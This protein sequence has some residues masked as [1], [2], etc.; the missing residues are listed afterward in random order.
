MAKKTV[1]PFAF[2][3]TLSILLSAQPL[4]AQR[5]KKQ[6]KCTLCGHD[7]ELLERNG[8]SHGPFPFA[9][10]T[11]ED[12]QIDMFWDAV[13]IET[14]HFRIAA[15]L[16]PWKVPESERKAYRA[17][18]TELQKKW[19]AI[20]PKKATL[21]PWLRA[22]LLADRCERAYA[23]FEELMGITPE[24]FADVEGLRARKMGPYLGM[25]DKFE[26][27]IF[28]DRAPFREFMEKTW[29]LTY[30][31]PQRWNNVDRGCLWFG[32]N[33]EEEDVR[34]DQHL[35]NMIR[36]NIAHNMLDGYMFYSYDLPVWISEGFAHWFERDNDPRFNMF[37]TV[38][39]SFHA[40][41]SLEKWA[42]EV[43]KLV[44]KGDAATYSSL[45]RRASFAEIDFN[46]HLVTWSK[47]DFLIQK[48][49]KK[50]GQFVT[51]LKGRKND[52]GLP[53]ASNLDGAQRD[54]FREL[55]GWTLPKLDETWTEWV[56]STYPVK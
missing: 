30:V 10:T 21:D 56:L 24:T 41:K 25:P 46:D 6:P 33:A 49:I 28:Q 48:D 42:P 27:M 50:F 32:L 26:I 35:H 23:Q 36:H 18:L 2:G 16:R 40:G 54:L 31:K 1:I 15:E 20:K 14:E 8:V 51:G 53:D 9:R 38:E 34:H 12:I 22:H 7:A 47:I 11:S 39:G 19:P 43:R 17:E 37:D 29:G 44:I 55:Y 5:N 45:L 4:S 3:L 52:R 13:W